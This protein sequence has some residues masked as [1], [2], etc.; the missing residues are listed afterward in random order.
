MRA[1]MAAAGERLDLSH[2]YLGPHPSSSMYR[3]G[4]MLCYTPQSQGGTCCQAFLFD[5]LSSCWLATPVDQNAELDA[6]G[7]WAALLQ[8]VAM[9]RIQPSLLFYMAHS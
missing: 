9:E 4:A 2:L 8:K 3:L 7:N 1:T 5:T 6:V